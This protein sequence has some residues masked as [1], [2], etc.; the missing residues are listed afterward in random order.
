MEERIMKV[1]H[2][3][4]YEKTLAAAGWHD[5]LE[6]T[7]VLFNN[8]NHADITS[9]EGI[10]AIMASEANREQYNDMVA[11]LVTND[12]Q[13]RDLV[14]DVARHTM[15]DLR[16][17]VPVRSGE[18]ADAL[19]NNANYNSLAKLNSWVIVGYTARSKA[20]EMFH[21]FTSDDPTVEFEYTLNY[22]VKGNDTKQYYRPMADRDGDLAFMYDLPQLLPYDNDTFLQTADNL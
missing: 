3:Q 22:T 1:I 4:K 19:A 5:K 10:K 15:N 20:M 6:E 7:M 2:A 13:T 17:H 14:K 9:E 16:N 8:R 21:T 18:A 12:E 11:S